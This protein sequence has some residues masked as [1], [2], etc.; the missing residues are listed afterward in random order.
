M[1]NTRTQRRE[2]E[3]FVVTD[4]VELAR[5]V[6]LV[7]IGCIDAVDVG[8]NFA[9][10]GLERGREGNC[11]GVL[12]TAAKSCDILVL[13]NALKA[14]DNHD[15]FFAELALQPLLVDAADPRDAMV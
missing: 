9:F 4:L 7:G 1:Q 15:I 11:G 10:F 3:H 8:I 6:N 12:T 14:R 2:F 5:G 13:V